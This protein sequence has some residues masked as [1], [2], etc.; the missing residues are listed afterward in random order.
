MVYLVA[1][2]H[3]GG[4]EEHSV[5]DCVADIQATDDLGVEECDVYLRWG[6]GAL[7]YEF[8]EEG[9]IKGQGI[10]GKLVDLR[11]GVVGFVVAKL[12]DVGKALGPD[13]GE[14]GGRGERDEG[15]AGADIGSGGLSPDV[16]FPGLEG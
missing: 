1:G 13:G 3:L 11:G 2:V 10:A 6:L 4:A 5:G 9:G 8:P 15:L 16:L 12:G 7:D 14:I